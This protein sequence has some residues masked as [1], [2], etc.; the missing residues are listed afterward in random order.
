MFF[1]Y[2]LPLKHPN[3]N[4]LC[5]RNLPLLQLQVCHP[6]LRGP[7]SNL[8][9]VYSLRHK[10]LYRYPQWK[11]N[12]YR[13]RLNL[14]LSLLTSP[15]LVPTTLSSPLIPS[16][17]MSKLFVSISFSRC[18]HLLTVG[19][20]LLP[21]NGDSSTRSFRPYSLHIRKPH[22]LAA[23]GST[24]C[25]PTPNT[26]KHRLDSLFVASALRNSPLPIF[27]PSVTFV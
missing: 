4:S 1:D 14:H 21:N 17:K 16:Q 2:P 8:P 22:Y 5:K 13:K 23:Q 11:K 27:V 12:A 3:P 25:R 15:A 9:L 10:S 7:S 24:R 6:L 19:N 20:S 26:Q 18:G